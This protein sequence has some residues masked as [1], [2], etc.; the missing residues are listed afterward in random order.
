MA[1][2][3]YSQA[4]SL[5]EDDEAVLKFT[6]THKLHE[7]WLSL[8]LKLDRRTDAVNFL[9][10]KGWTFKVHELLVQ[11]LKNEDSVRSVT[12]YILSRLWTIFLWV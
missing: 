4:R 3:F 8:L 7:A 2:W 11:D 6:E 9:I 12:K 5:F 1:F 10:L